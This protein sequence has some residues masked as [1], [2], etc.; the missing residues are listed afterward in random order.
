MSGRVQANLEQVFS[1]PPFCLCLKEVNWVQRQQ[2]RNPLFGVETGLFFFL[3]VVAVLEDQPLDRHA[4]FF[5]A[6]ELTQS[7]KTLHPGSD[8]LNSFDWYYLYLTKHFILQICAV[9]MMC[10][11]LIPYSFL[12]CAC[13]MSCAH[14]FSKSFFDFDEHVSTTLKIVET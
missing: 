10:R 1:P 11:L 13:C 12:H 4:S 6:P 7:D 8:F 9:A 3:I 5:F 14:V 2:L